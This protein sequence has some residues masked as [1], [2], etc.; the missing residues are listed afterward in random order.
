MSNR[1]QRESWSPVVP[2]LGF[3][4]G[5]RWMGRTVLRVSSVNGR[6]LRDTVYYSA[7]THPPTAHINPRLGVTWFMKGS[8]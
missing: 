4:I 5:F 8:Q 7:E 6:G 3:D 2:I 1:S